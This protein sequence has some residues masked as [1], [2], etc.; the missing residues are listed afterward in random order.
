MSH[1]LRQSSRRMPS[2]YRIMAYLHDAGLLTKVDNISSS[3]M[4]VV[5]PWPLSEGRQHVTADIILTD[6]DDRFVP[7]VACRIVYDIEHLD[8]DNSFSGT[9][10]RMVGLEFQ[11]LNEVQQQG[12]D[13]IIERL[14][15][16]L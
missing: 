4:S 1:E 6:T 8:E 16:S 2:H 11:Q 3:G 12:L 9:A 15:V 7:A 13:T 14:P 5:C 10:S